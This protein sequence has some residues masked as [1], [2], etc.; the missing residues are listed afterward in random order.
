MTVKVRLS[1]EPELIAGVVAQL[2]ENYEVA[3]GDRSYP[4][5]GSLGVRVYIEI[6]P[7]TTQTTTGNT[8]RKS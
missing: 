3:G 7:T 4:N 8:R 2:R 1:G 5:R 6:R